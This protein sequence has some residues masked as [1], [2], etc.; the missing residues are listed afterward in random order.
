MPLINQPIY[1]EIFGNLDNQYPVASHI[2]QNGFY[3][4]CHPDIN[5][6]DLDYII[7]I[8]KKFFDFQ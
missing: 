5:K 1:R 3:I 7:Y 4:G 8:F 2:N 6:E